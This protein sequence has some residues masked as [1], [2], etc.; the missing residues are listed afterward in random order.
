MTR[1]G[2]T[3]ALDNVARKA[4]YEDDADYGIVGLIVVVFFACLIVSSWMYPFDGVIV[5]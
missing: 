3:K 2:L 5:P 1:D 4:G